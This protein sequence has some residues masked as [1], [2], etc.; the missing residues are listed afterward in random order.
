MRNENEE[1]G[2]TVVAF[3]AGLLIGGLLVWVFSGTEPVEIIEEEAIVTEQP[4]DTY[5]K[6]IRMAYRFQNPSFWT[7]E[8]EE[9]VESEEIIK[10]V[11]HCLKNQ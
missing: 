5:G 2:K 11:D 1:G 10:L 3:I 6:C 8:L 7:G 9:A 4:D